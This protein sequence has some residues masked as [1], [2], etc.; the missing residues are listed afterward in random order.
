M[1]SRQIYPRSPPQNL[2]NQPDDKLPIFEGHFG[3][4][5]SAPNST[6]VGLDDGRYPSSPLGGAGAVD[7]I[8][9]SRGP[10]RKLA[11]SGDVK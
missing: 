3:E 8:N 9:T 4:G 1:R 2:D 5:K 6:L 7:L 10:G 11:G